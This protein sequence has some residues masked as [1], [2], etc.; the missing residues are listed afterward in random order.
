MKQLRRQISLFSLEVTGDSNFRRFTLSNI[1]N[2]I[3]KRRLVVRASSSDSF[4]CFISPEK[5]MTE[6]WKR[7]LLEN[8]R[9]LFSSHWRGLGTRGAASRH[10]CLD[11][12]GSEL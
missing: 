2:T 8:R 10:A 1:Y 9:S 7:W 4:C 6:F 5:P 11:S 3:I 12:R